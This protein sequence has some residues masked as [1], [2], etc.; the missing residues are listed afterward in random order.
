MHKI[1]QTLKRSV[2]TL[3]PKYN[4]KN[5]EEHK[6]VTH[7]IL[8]VVNLQSSSIN[9][10]PAS[11]ESTIQSAPTVS[12]HTATVSVG[13]SGTL[14]SH[15]ALITPYSPPFLDFNIPACQRLIERTFAPDELLALIQAVLTN[16][17]EGNTIRSL[18]GDDAQKFIDVIDDVGFAR[19][20]TTK[21]G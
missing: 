18:H 1:K 6:L 7:E 17:D 15:T 8:G 3:H 21:S 11:I 16:T 5:V 20:P 12:E 14:I 9:E 4:T 13:M 19:S 2:K 10:D